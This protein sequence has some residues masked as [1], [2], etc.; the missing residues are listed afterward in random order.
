MPRVRRYWKTS[1]YVG[2]AWPVGPPWTPSRI[3]GLL[4]GSLSPGTGERAG[5]RGDGIN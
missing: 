2:R 5:E 3:G 1:S 4:E